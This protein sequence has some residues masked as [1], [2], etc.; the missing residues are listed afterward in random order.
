MLTSTRFY[1]VLLFSIVFCLRAMAQAPTGQLDGRVFD[2]TGALIPG[3]SV[4]LTN[5]DTGASR[6]L[7]SGGDGFFSF[8]SLQAG[9]YEIRCEAPGCRPM[10]QPVTVQTGA[11]ATV[12]IH[13]QV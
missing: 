10:E 4:N 5:A 1:A 12:D 3:A 9:K 7:S 6:K 11:I 8:P 13:M 2:E